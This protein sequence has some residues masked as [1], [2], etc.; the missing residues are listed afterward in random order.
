MHCFPLYS[1]LSLNF[2]QGSQQHD[3][4]RLCSVLLHPLNQ[5]VGDDDW[6]TVRIGHLLLFN[7]GLGEAQCHEDMVIAMPESCRELAGISCA[8]LKTLYL[9]R[10]LFYPWLRVWD[11]SSSM[12]IV[13]IVI[14]SL[15]IMQSIIQYTNNWNNAMHNSIMNMIIT[16]WKW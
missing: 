4:L 2:L 16:T 8:Q 5:Q 14:T 7:L 13:L 10:Q 1:A 12:I 15:T 3:P 9:A 11:T 6:R